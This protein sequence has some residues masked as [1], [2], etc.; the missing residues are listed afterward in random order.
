MP[1]RAQY[2]VAF[3][4][5]WDMEPYY[6]PAAVGKD[7]KLNVVGAYAL[8]FAGFENNPRSMYL[9]ADMPLYALK[10]YH[11]VGVSLLNDQIGLFTHQR[12]A[13]QYAYR[14]RLFG[15][16]I[17]AGVQLGFINEK[18][19]GSKADLEDTA[20]R[21]SRARTSTETPLTWRSDYITPADRGMWAC[22]RSTSTHR[23]WNLARQTSCR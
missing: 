14:H 6:N 21:R 20:T 16:R 1:A 5:Y 12:M 3:S 18:F 22:R 23:S 7:T 11:G 19:D 4:H 8:D 13:L 15:G 10:A 17:A 2:D 9:G